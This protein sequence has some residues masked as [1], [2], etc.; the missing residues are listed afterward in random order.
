MIKLID[1]L[2]VKYLSKE[3]N[4]FE[5]EELNYLISKKKNHK[6][7]KN[8]TYTNYL[9][10]MSFNN[11]DLDKGKRNIYNRIKLLERKNKANRFKKLA[12]AAS[13]GLLIGITFYQYFYSKVPLD[14]PS[15]VEIVRAGPILT[16]DNS[17]EVV[18][19]Q[20][21]KLKAK[22]ININGKKLSYGLNNISND[23]VKKAG[24]NIL[25]IPKAT[26]FIVSLEDGT[27]IHLNANS[28]IKYPVSFVKGETRQVELLYGEAFF[29]VS[30]SK[31]N[32]GSAFSVITES[33][34]IN[35]LGTAFNVKAYSDNSNLI[36]TVETTLIE[37]SLTVTKGMVTKTL[38]PNQQSK[39]DL[40]LN[41]FQVSNVDVS[42]Y[43]SWVDGLFTFNNSSLYSIMQTLSRWYD[44]EFSFES[45]DLKNFLFSGAIEKTTPLSDLLLF[46]EKSSDKEVKFEI[47]QNSVLI[48]QNPKR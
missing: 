16:L 40:N 3:A 32:N 46:I 27:K 38:I 26:Q 33:H 6:L 5:K 4:L 13:I 39:V 30:S 12:F 21:K 45:P 36:P 34:K 20:G 44:I 48:L 29:D 31:I 24:S 14:I 41:E 8:F 15:P 25:T 35:V 28:K 37:G 7:F 19:E 42:Q 22:G 17:D 9:S 43:I 23:G 11:H 47:N 1:S 10:L 2:I 18:L